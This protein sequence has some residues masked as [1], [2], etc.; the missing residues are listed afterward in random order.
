MSIDGF[1]S[2]K[3]KGDGYYER[4][5]EIYYDQRNYDPKH[6]TYKNMKSQALQHFIMA[7]LMKV[8][9]ASKKHCLVSNDREIYEPI[10]ALEKDEEFFPVFR[11]CLKTNM[12][13][14]FSQKN[15]A[16]KK[17]VTNFNE[18]NINSHLDRSIDMIKL[19]EL[20]E[21]DIEMY[22]DFR[23]EVKAKDYYKPGGASEEDDE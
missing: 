9:E 14:Y 21:S 6:Y 5:G 15:A 18:Q 11:Q 10:F 12:L 1:S 4:N 13:D 3:Y 17:D 8:A 7:E 23:K 22:T 19:S 20:K 16:L 2:T